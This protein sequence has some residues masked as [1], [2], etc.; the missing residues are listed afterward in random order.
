MEKNYDP[1]NVLRYLWAKLIAEDNIPYELTDFMVFIENKNEPEVYFIF[2]ADKNNQ[3]G[4]YRGD[5]DTLNI[6]WDKETDLSQENIG[7][8]FVKFQNK[9]IK[10]FDSYDEFWNYIKG[11]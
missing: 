4:L 11:Y 7:K 8:V 2:G 9:V 3:D 10:P 6:K 1:H 5:W